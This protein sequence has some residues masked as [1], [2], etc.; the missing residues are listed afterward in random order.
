MDA[1]PPVPSLRSYA[2][3]ALIAI[4]LAAVAA[5]FCLHREGT[6]DLFWQMKVGELLLQ[7]GAIPAADPFSFT[8]AGAPWVNGEWLAG[9]IFFLAWC[10][11]GFVG[12]S[13]LSFLVG[14][15][16][17][18][19]L[20]AGLRSLARSDAA[21]LLLTLAAFAAG[22]PRLQQLRPELLGFLC[23]AL[24]LALLATARPGLGRRLFWILPL[25]VLWINVHP[26]GIVGP[27]VMALFVAGILWQGRHHANI[28]PLPRAR[29]IL[30][31]VLCAAAAL[32]NP[33]GT[34]VY[35]YPFR[36]LSSS[37]VMASSTDWS[38]PRWFSPVIDVAPWAMAALA[39]AC[40]VTFLRGGRRVPFP[41]LLIALVFV[42][43]GFH[44]IRFTAFAVIALCFLF[45]A[46]LGGRAESQAPPGR[47]FAAAVLLCV[48]AALLLGNLGPVYAIQQRPGGIDLVLGRPIG[49]GLDRESFPMEAV[50]ALEGM[51]CDPLFND[52][53]YGGYLIWRRSPQARVFIDTRTQLYGDAFYKAYSDALFLPA[54]FEQLTLRYGIRCVLYD[55][56][57]IAHPQ[58][59]LHFLLGNS[60][61][62]VAFRSANAVIFRKAPEARP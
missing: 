11:A 28:L 59:P 49:A 34:E 50:D 60:G 61:W 30:I 45:A 54:A 51:G 24:L 19:G 47:A 55:A 31:A 58:G 43:A 29:L 56:R 27:G 15:G 16:I 41:F 6:S 44:M 10:A 32:A 13:Y 21:A 62:P 26:S 8:A 39:L 4:A 36:E 22:A 38:T 1:A 25:E 35:L 9:V 23:V 40:L 46:L 42:P 37:F 12:L 5:L 18:A 14:L 2:V 52:M 7:Q 57:E 20:F 3:A 48:G 17:A 53:G 33:Y